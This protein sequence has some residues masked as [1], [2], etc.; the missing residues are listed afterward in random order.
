MEASAAA[1]R[2]AVVGLVAGNISGR[3]PWIVGGR[4][5]AQT[6][7]TDEQ[8]TGIQGHRR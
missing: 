5:E 2:A 3:K 6:V 8:R 7:A 4:K 1:V